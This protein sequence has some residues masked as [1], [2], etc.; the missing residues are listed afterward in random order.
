MHV[1]ATAGHVD[2]G[3]STLVRALTGHDP[4]RLEEERRRGL[5]IELGFCWTRLGEVGDVAFVDVPGHERFVS[6]MLAG[7]GAVPAV[8]FVVAAD[9]PWMPQA[10]EHLA[11]LDAW[12][13]R[14]G[15]LA[16]TRSDLADPAPAL[17]RAGEELRRTS[18]GEVP[19]IAVSGTTGQGMDQLRSA[20][21]D[22]VA[23]LPEPD[24][25]ADVRLWADRVFHVRGAGTVVTGTLS[26]GTLRVGDRLVAHGSVLRVRG[27]ESL[28]RPVT[29]ARGACRVAVN[30]AGTVPAALGRGSAL[31]SPVGWRTTAVLDAGVDRPGGLPRNPMLHVG[32]ASAPVHARPLDDHYVR[33][34]L[35]EELPLRVGD[36]AVLRDPGSREVWGVRVLDPRPP[37]LRRRGAARLRAK[38]L[39]ASDGSVADELRRR[40]VVDRRLLR[41]LGVAWPEITP[42]GSVRVGDWLVAS[43]R[44]DAWRGALPAA[45]D[46]AARPTEPWVPLTAVA[47]ALGAPAPDLV[48]AVVGPPFQVAEG[49]VRR[50]PAD[51][52]LPAA[53]AEP[54]ARLSVHLVAQPFRAPTAEELVTLGLDRRTVAALARAGRVV[55]LADGVVLG[56]DDIEA[57]MEVLRGLPDPFTVSEARQALGSSRRVVLPLLAHLDATRRTRRLPDDRRTPL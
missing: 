13:V 10:A 39:A 40:G 51:D 46:A 12:G 4:D 14:H 3:K 29:E 35:T 2:H 24:P 32:A 20:L 30:L 43:E 25:A 56:V 31:V 19:A 41:E 37:A 22:L 21:S 7:V 45:V 52:G 44:A 49:R 26:A 55:V 27:L 5:S 15:V 28:G 11:A 9:D 38:D 34:T 47:R 17:R 48:A 42:V 33:L 8:L 53:L 18:L 6:T 23:A 54:L 50:T 1:V 16:V 36:R 57:A